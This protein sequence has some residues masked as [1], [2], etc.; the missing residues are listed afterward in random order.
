MPPRKPSD[1]RQNN[2]TKDTVVELVPGG[3]V[4][5]DAPDRWLPETVGEWS[6]FWADAELV[7]IVR[8]AQ[9]PALVRLFDWRDR[10]RRAWSLADSLR[11]A[12][13]DEHFTA[14]STGQVKANP[15][16]E[17]AEKAEASALQIEGR[18][19]ALED[20]FGLSPQSML[21]LGVDFQKRQGLEARNR[22]MS[23]ALN[24]HGRS[25]TADD[26]RSLPGDTAVGSS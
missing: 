10:L 3:L 18:V 20:R 17:R 21:K 4:V 7:S 2:I 6:L 22:Q 12:I 5:P 16:Y 9:R 26:P 25:A 14:G 11:D 24:D 1:R 8:E 23:E 13:G 15:L 19:E